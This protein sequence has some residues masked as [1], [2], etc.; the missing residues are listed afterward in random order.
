MH[1]LS[2]VALNFVLVVAF[3]PIAHE[4][5]TADLSHEAYVLGKY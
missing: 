5:A 3:W 4:G 2:S 1:A